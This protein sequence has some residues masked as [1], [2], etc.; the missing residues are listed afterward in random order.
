MPHDGYSGLDDLFNQWQLMRCALDFHRMSPGMHQLLH[1]IHRRFKAFAAAK[2]R[3]VSDDEF[4]GRTSCYCGGMH[5]HHFDGRVYRRV[6][7]MHDHCE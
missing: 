5:H 4:F 7:T 6:E 2:K 1:S 3:H